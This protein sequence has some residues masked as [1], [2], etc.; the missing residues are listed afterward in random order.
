MAPQADL[1]LRHQVVGKVAVHVLFKAFPAGIHQ[2]NAGKGGQ[3]EPFV[4]RHQAPLTA[5]AVV[6][7]FYRGRGRAQQ[8]LGLVVGGQHQGHFPGV[9]T[10]RGVV[11]LIGRLVFLVDDDQRQVVEG[12]KDGRAHAHHH[13]E[14]AR[15]D[16]V[17]DLG[18]FVVGEFGVV[19]AQAVAEYLQVPISA[20]PDKYFDFDLADFSRKFGFEATPASYALKL[21]EQEGLWTLSEAVF[22][23]ATVQFTTS[24]EELDNVMHAHPELA[25][26]ITALL[27]L[28]GSVFYYPTPVR[29]AVV[30]KQM[31]VRREHADAL[32]TRLHHME[33]LEYNKPKDGPQLFF[34]HY[35]V[36]SRHLI[37]DAKRITTLKKQHEARLRAMIA[38]LETDDAQQAF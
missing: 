22:S 5:F 2:L 38:Y 36:D 32:I 18:P 13:R 25:M 27:R 29:T 16:A 9:I 14:T 37:I 6:I 19:H 20:Q 30:A 28:Y 24:R 35:R 12:Q 34:H 3:P 17:P 23:P 7:G 4:H 11:L 8:G 1:D 21:L 31:K 10:G 33:V 15:Q 26:A